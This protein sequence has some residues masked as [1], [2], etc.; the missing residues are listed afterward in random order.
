MYRFEICANSV[1]SCIAVQEGGADGCRM[2]QGCPLASSDPRK[3]PHD[4]HKA[5]MLFFMVYGYPY[6]LFCGF[7][8]LVA[9]IN[10]NACDSGNMP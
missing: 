2:H 1:A 7:T 3:R 4:R 6:Y 9:V 5:I 10:P 8:Y